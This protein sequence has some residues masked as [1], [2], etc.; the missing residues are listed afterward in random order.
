M[1]DD[2]KRA[3][4]AQL[5]LKEKAL[6]LKERQH[7]LSV[8]WWRRYVAIPIVSLA[9]FALCGI[10]IYIGGS[11][12]GFTGRCGDNSFIKWCIVHRYDCAAS[13]SLS[14]A[15][16]NTLHVSTTTSTNE[17]HEAQS[18]VNA[19]TIFS[20][21]NIATKKKCPHTYLP[22]VALILKSFFIFA[23]LGV[24]AYTVRVVVSHHDND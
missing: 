12:F 7:S 15:L 24:A 17:A 20:Q 23:A 1:T 2:D 11:G 19:S 14:P 18:S 9:I 4:E 6:A 8:K 3:I 16:T 21:D 13:S 5:A 22:I 10:A